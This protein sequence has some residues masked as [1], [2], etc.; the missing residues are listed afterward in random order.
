VTTARIILPRPHPIQAQIIREARRFNV[1]CL[2]RRLGKST[3]GLD[4]LVR[5]AL[6][7]YPV[8]WFSPEQKFHELTWRELLKTLEPVILYKN[9]TDQRID[10]VGGGSVDMFNLAK[11]Q[12][13]ARGRKYKRI[14]IDE[15]AQVTHLAMAWEQAIR[16]TLVDYTGDAWILSTPR[17]FSY[18]YTLYCKGVDDDKKV[19]DALEAGLEPPPVEWKSWNFPSTANPHL[20]PEELVKMKEE[21]TPKTYSQEVLAQFL[22]EGTAVFPHVE[23][24]AT[25]KLQEP[26]PSHQYACGI[27]WGRSDDL[28]SF[29]VI[30]LTTKAIVWIETTSRIEFHHQRARLQ[31][32]HDRYHFSMI[33]CEMNSIGTPNFEELQR[34]GLPVTAFWT[35][36]ASK[37]EAVD[38]L[39]LALSRRQLVLLDRDQRVNGTPVGQRALEELHAF[40][41]T[42]LPSGLTRYAAPEG[43]HDDIC[44]SILLAWLCCVA[45][46]RAAF[47]R[48]H[49]DAALA[50]HSSWHL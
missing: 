44:V 42:R 40:A 29:A 48:A 13:V 16:A 47:D 4:R 33:L 19:A 50:D 38:A 43:T 35:T 5:P 20:P 41:A 37:T 12:N 9:S 27:D 11:P 45:P 30:D 24:S 46:E 17:G 23:E 22:G 28:T 14:V 10:L 3:L 31:G 39:V 21:M 18:F 26:I 6:A 25:G 7:G 2:G 32:L 1:L 8:A 49:V 15:A 34:I 36:N